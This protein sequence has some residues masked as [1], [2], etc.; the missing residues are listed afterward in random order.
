[1]SREDQITREQSDVNRQHSEDRDKEDDSRIKVIYQV[2]ATLIG[3]FFGAGT[4][5]LSTISPIGF[6]AIAVVILSAGI[7]LK[8]LRNT[9]RT[10]LMIEA[11]IAMIATVVSIQFIEENSALVAAA[12]ILLYMLIS[13]IDMLFKIRDI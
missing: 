13:I 10:A 11:P 6:I 12:L 1:M 5:T 4:Q 9:P 7:S 2:V 3:V 8:K